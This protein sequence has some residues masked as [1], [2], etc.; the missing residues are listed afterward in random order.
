MDIGP[1]E[2]VIILLIVVILFGGSRISQLGGELGS[3]IHEF[4]K[5]LQDPD[6]TDTKSKNLPSEEQDPNER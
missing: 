5:S 4:R 2:L 3:A 6:R 1:T